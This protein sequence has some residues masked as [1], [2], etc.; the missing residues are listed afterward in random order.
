MEKKLVFGKAGLKNTTPLWIKWIYRAFGI[1]G[2]IWVLVSSN[3]S[4]EIPVALQ[5]QITK[6]ILVGGGIIYAV[7]QCFGYADAPDEPVGI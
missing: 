4:T 6:A 3:Y 5:A 1:A 2:V 7:A